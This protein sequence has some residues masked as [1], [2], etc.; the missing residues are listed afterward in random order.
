[1]SKVESKEVS[2]VRQYSR[3]RNLTHKDHNIRYFQTITYCQRRKNLI[4]SITIDKA[5]LNRVE[6]IRQGI[7]LFMENSFKQDELPHIELPS[8]SFRKLFAT[9]THFL[10]DIPIGI[11]I[12][13][14]V[15]SCDLYKAP[16]FD[17]FNLNFIR[18]MWTTIGVDIIQF[19]QSFFNLENFLSL[20]SI[21]LC[22]S[23]LKSK[24]LL[25]LRN[26]GQ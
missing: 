8:N 22:V 24:T 6:E 25:R 9:S 1:M 5:V 14:A 11:E 7:R 12:K 10:E 2:K 21:P 15:S 13:E 4:T 18:K 23:F 19:V 3:V 20:S 17:G 26:L 16:D